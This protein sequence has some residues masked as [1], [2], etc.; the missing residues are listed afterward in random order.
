MIQRE[1]V[2]RGVST[3]GLVVAGTAG[4]II[5]AIALLTG[6]GGP[7]DEVHH[8]TDLYTVEPGAFEI[9][10]PASGELAA[11]D[12]VELR[13]ELDGTA[14]ITE[15]IAEGSS[16]NVGDVLVQLDDQN[17]RE[18]I[19]SAEEAVVAAKNQVETRTA[20]LAITKNARDSS[21]AQAQVAVDQ[22]KLALL[23]WREGEVVA[24]R[25][26]LSLAL[27]TAEKDFKRLEEKYQ[28]SLDL[29]KRDFISQNDLEQDEIQMIR[30]EAQLSQSRLDQEVYEKYTYEKDKQRKESDL[31]QAE[32]ELERVRTRTNASVRSAES[33]LDAAQANLVSKGERLAQYQQQLVSCTV[34]AT[35]S[36]MVVYGT[37]LS[38]G[39]RSERDEA[40]RV[41]SKVSRN[42]LLIVLPNTDRMFANVKVNEALS[43]YVK[44][45]QP[46]TV[47]MD[48]FDEQT[49]VGS[50]SSVGVLAEDGGW[51]DP[52]R[53]DYSVKVL[54]E[55]GGN[56][57]LKPS[58]RCKAR[59]LID[60]V[61]ES[62]FVPVQS[63]HRGPNGSIVY[64]AEGASYRPRSVDLGRSSELF[65]EVLGGLTKGDRV[66]LRDPPPGTVL[67][68]QDA[69]PQP[70]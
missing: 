42:Q 11:M 67:G 12:Q 15:I 56:L 51:R 4:V 52:N 59:I 62:L 54:L 63:V 46:A 20:D 29:R 61:V 2:R 50:V 70:S 37:T 10:I 58:M 32:D 55:N 17:V 22:N 41:G 38:G 65:V 9:L 45:G 18:R 47:R 69:S 14:T 6:G 1:Q 31:K 48:A 34:K 40:L 39:R 21:L 35:A 13:S 49:I 28:K 24:K 43:G 30:A 66:L 44:A 57:P 53:R 5:L 8:K 19:Q 60:T 33:N 64:V 36:G 27:R 23:A 68:L 7:Q 25:N 16:V 26:Q 3:T